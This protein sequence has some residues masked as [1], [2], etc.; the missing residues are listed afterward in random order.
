MNFV[1]LTLWLC[2][3]GS[4]L[5]VIRSNPWRPIYVHNELEFQIGRALVLFAALMLTVPVVAACSAH[6]DYSASRVS[7]V[8]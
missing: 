3:V 4:V 7:Q 6:W 8:A 1:A 2:L 5:L